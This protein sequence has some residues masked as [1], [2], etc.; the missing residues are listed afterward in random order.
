MIE[1]QC[2]TIGP[3]RHYLYT[4]DGEPFGEAKWAKVDEAEAAELHNE[5]HQTTKSAL[6]E[7]RALF[8]NIKKDMAEAGCKLV[9]VYDTDAAVDKTRLRY[10]RFMGFKTFGEMDGHKFAVQEVAPCQ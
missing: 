6:V 1:C 7:S 10:W 3:W 2:F 9:Y 5:M 8:E 4:K